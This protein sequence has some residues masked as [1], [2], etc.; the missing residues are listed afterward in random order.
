MQI[1]QLP[2]TDPRSARRSPQG[3]RQRCPR[4]PRLPRAQRPGPAPVPTVRPGR[5]LQGR[6]VR[7]E[8]GTGPGG[9]WHGLRQVSANIPP[10]LTVPVTHPSSLRPRQVSQENEAR[11]TT[12]HAR[13][14]EPRCA[15]APSPARRNPPVRRLASCPQLP[16]ERPPRWRPLYPPHRHYARPPFAAVTVPPRHRWHADPVFSTELQSA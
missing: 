13:Q 16:L 6:Q 1:H 7:R 11:R 12:R 10:L 8:V 15:D 5:T 2:A 14:P 4:R 3:P 9:P